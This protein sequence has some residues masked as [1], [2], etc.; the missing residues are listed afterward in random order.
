VAVSYRV[1][2]E[3][4]RYWQ[5]TRLPER[6][7]PR[8]IPIQTSCFL[9]AGTGLITSFDEIANPFSNL[10]DYVAVIFIDLCNSAVFTVDGK[11]FKV[12]ATITG[13]YVRLQSKVACVRLNLFQS[14]LLCKAL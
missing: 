8:I 10:G 9:Y 1:I 13:K 4:G 7:P 14:L 5:G 12:P 3:S 11:P 6:V 2:L